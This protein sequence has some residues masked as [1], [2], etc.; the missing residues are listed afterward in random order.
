VEFTVE[1]VHR[2]RID[3]EADVIVYNVHLVCHIES[4]PWC[5]TPR[6]LANVVEAERVR[7]SSDEFARLVDSL[8][9]HGLEKDV[10]NV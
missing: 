5:L 8:R 3:N 1:S 2:L 4:T 6:Q 10:P 7:L 9:Q